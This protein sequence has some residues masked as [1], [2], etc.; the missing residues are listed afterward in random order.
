[1]DTDSVRYSRAGDVFHYRW[2]ARRCLRMVHPNSQLKRMSVEGTP[3]DASSGD[4]VI[5]VAEYFENE[6]G[7]VDRIEYYQLKH[8]SE[9][10]DDP[11]NLSG[12]KKAVEGFAERFVEVNH[13]DQPSEEV[14]DVR[15]SIITNRPIS[16]RFKENVEKIGLGEEAESRFRQTIESYTG[17]SGVGLEAFCRSLRLVDSERDYAVQRHQLQSEISILVA[18]SV[19]SALLGKVEALVKERALPDSSGE[20]YPEDVLRRFGVALST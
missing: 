1:M 12:L 16:Q 6:E 2:A 5:D 8:T 14:P 17:L 13:E 11:F 18:G 19:G 9:R 15:F 20:I 7:T 10:Q 3:E 4:E